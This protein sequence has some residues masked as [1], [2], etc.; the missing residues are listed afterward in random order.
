MAVFL[1]LS[2]L[3]G[4]HPSGIFLLLAA[5]LV[6]PIKPIKALISKLFEKEF[7][8]TILAVLVV[9]CGI[10]FY[11][12]LSKGKDTKTESYNIIFKTDLSSEAE[13]SSD[14]LKPEAA[15]SSTTLGEVI[16][17]DEDEDETKETI[18]VTILSLTTPVGNGQM[19]EL[20]MQGEP[21]TNYSILVYYSE[22]PSEAKGLEDKVSD[23][24]GRITWKWRIGSRTKTGEHKIVIKNEKGRFETFIT[25]E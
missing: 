4:L 9:L 21:N 22:K 14:T 12:A 16:T 24:N 15:A 1:I 11:P 8:A 17:K 23:K 10:S 6:M 3:N 20:E 18:A 7:I 25:V 2:L 19:A 13:T 5:I